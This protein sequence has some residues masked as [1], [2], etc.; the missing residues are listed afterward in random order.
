MKSGV[1]REAGSR[2]RRAT[3]KL[4]KNSS[5]SLGGHPIRM[6]DRKFR[7]LPEKNLNVNAFN[8]KT[9]NAESRK[10]LLLLLRTKN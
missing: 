10:I 3:N 6:P 2:A 5:V 7:R 4:E 9:K 1:T 8:S